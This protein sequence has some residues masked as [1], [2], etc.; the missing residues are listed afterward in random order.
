MEKVDEMR[1]KVDE[2]FNIDPNTPK[3]CFWFPLRFGMW[4]IWG[5]AIADLAY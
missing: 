2:K 4:L 5:L 3:C 1:K